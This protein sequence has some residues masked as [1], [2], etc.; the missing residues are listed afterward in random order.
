MSCVIYQNMQQILPK[1]KTNLKKIKRA[2]YEATYGENLKISKSMQDNSLVVASSRSELIKM[3]LQLQKEMI[4][5][6]KEQERYMKIMQ[7]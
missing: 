6:L 7:L 3:S 5:M 1:N 4:Q 2:S